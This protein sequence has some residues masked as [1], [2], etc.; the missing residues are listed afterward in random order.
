MKALSFQNDYLKT[1]RKLVDILWTA[2]YTGPDRALIA[3][4]E[5]PR[6]LCIIT[7]N[8][9]Q[10][11]DIERNECTNCAVLLDGWPTTNNELG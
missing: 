5:E 10:L 3:L 6:N 9:I 11:C 7:R 8:C 2:G 4:Q 1:L